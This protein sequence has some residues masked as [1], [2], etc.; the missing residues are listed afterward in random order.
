MAYERR[1]NGYELMKFEEWTGE[2]MGC[3]EGHGFDNAALTEKYLPGYYM[4]MEYM[5]NE[6]HKKQ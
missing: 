5:K 3:F 1:L 4:Q 2:I 6:F